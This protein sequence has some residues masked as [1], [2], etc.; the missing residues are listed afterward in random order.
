[1][2]AEDGPM[3]RHIPRHERW[4]RLGPN[5]YKSGSAVVRFDK[6][7]WWAVVSYQQLP[8]DTPAP[9]PGSVAPRSDRLGPFKRPRNAMVAA[10]NHVTLLRRRHGNQAILGTPDVNP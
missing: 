6:G 10:E 2:P 7:A 8:A 9:V 5:E 1:M 3:S 4:S